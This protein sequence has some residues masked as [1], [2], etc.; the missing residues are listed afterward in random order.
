MKTLT[1]IQYLEGVKVLTRVD[2]NV[3]II[4]CAMRVA[5][6]FQPRGPLLGPRRQVSNRLVRRKTAG[7]D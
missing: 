6:A 3:P 4:A 2:F 7:Y 5:M 1:D